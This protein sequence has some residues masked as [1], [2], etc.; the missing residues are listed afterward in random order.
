MMAIVVHVGIAMV[1]LFI[2]FSSKW[3]YVLICVAA[4]LLLSLFIVY[5]S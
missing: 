5:D 4:I 3:V 2:V 1:P